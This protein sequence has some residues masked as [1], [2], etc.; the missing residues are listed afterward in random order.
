MI[1]FDGTTIILRQLKQLM[2]FFIYIKETNETWNGLHAN[3]KF[4]FEEEKNSVISFLDL[5]IQRNGSK[6]ETEI[7]RK[8]TDTGLYVKY[9]KWINF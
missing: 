8:D 3:I 5:F 2:R 4:T 6:Y 7:Y 9:D 1:Y